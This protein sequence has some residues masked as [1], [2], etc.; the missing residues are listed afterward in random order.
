[1]HQL[2]IFRCDQTLDVFLFDEEGDRYGSLVGLNSD[3]VAYIQQN[4][5]HAEI[6]VNDTIKISAEIFKY[7][8]SNDELDVV[9]VRFTDDDFCVLQNKT[10]S[11]FA[12]HF[13]L[14]HSYFCNLHR[15]LDRLSL[16]MIKCLLPIYPPPNQKKLPKVN[17]YNLLDK[18]YQLLALKRMMAC[19]SSMPFLVTGPFGT[20]KTRLLATA[21]VKFLET[22]SSRVLI[23]TSH[24]QSADAYIDN[25]FGPML[26]DGFINCSVKRLT[27]KDYVLYCGHYQH[28]FTDGYEE[29][30][31][32]EI[33][34]CRLIITTFLKAPHLIFCNVRPFT[35]ILIDEGAQTR[36]PEAIAPL[37]LADDDT[38]IIIAGDHL[39]VISFNISFIS[40]FNFYRL[41]LK[42]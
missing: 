6:Q 17:S 5:V 22:R 13:I 18:D 7:N 16:S 11:R 30:K 21:A 2:L 24:L 27:A 41:V 1:M 9:H 31:R 40:T 42:C 10:E 8:L 14:K 34:K 19:D 28:L 15:S 35:H 4:V 33:R 32:N 37:A 29:R 26:E 20:G 25:Y 39:Q 38:K 3:D 23:C 36:E 12:V